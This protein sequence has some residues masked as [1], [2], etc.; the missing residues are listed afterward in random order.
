MSRI[1]I[2]LSGGGHRASLFGLGVLAYLCDAGKSA[3]VVSIASVSGGSITNAFVA[4]EID[5]A[6]A[7]PAELDQRVT[8]PLAEQIARRGTLFA[9][10]PTRL[11]LALI[12]AV[13]LAALAAPWL[14]PI[15]IWAAAVAGVA[16]LL[17]VALLAW[18]RGNVCG[19]AYR[20]TLLSRDGRATRLAEV[21]RAVHHL[22]CATDLRTGRPV[23]FTPGFIYGYG[24]G[25]CPP[26]AVPLYKAVQASAAFPGGFPPVRIPTRGLGFVETKS[27]R[28]KE[29]PSGR[30]LL[31]DGGVYDNLAEQWARGF[32]G[33][34][35]RWPELGDD[36]FEPDTL[37]VVN[38]SARVDWMPYGRKPPGWAEVAALM[39]DMNVLYE[40]TTAV[41]RQEL[42]ARFDRAEKRGSGLRGALVMIRQSPWQLASYYS[43]KR[44]RA[45]WPER[46][47][48][49]DAVIELLASEG[50]KRW[51]ELA[52]ANAAVPTTL[53][54]L[55]VETSA[56]LLR[57]AYVLAMCNL[58]VALGLPLL[59]LPPEADFVALA[60][61]RTR[62]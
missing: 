39:R 54:A 47:A 21:G 56:R 38:S 57:H 37:V 3:E 12:A 25:R 61:G 13:A 20:D 24:F 42:T 6:E 5:F 59:E 36:Y 51:S 49:A 8:A 27:G 4:Q 33:R 34:V 28:P 43:G 48:R 9:T 2:A 16:G 26:G 15:P 60:E 41:R 46:G 29:I 23:Y 19:R 10:W 45:E 17:L 40:N 11:Y 52:A 7:T 1:A 22:I 55:G 44:V 53:S 14:L 35:R 18:Q 31:A 58:H 50:R 30:L 32:A 62:A